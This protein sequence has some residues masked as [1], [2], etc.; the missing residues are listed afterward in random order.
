MFLPAAA[1]PG[2]EKEGGS[3]DARGDFEGIPGAC[4]WCVALRLIPSSNPSWQTITEPPCLG[5]P[6][7]LLFAFPSTYRSAVGGSTGHCSG[8][9]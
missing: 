8:T 6:L 3:G 5:A 9:M 2:M 4:H 7:T 1:A